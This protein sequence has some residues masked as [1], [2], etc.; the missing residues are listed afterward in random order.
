FSSVRNADL[1]L[2]KIDPGHPFG[3][4]MLHLDSCIHFHEIEVPVLLEQK[5]DRSRIRIMSR[6]GRLYRSLSHLRTKLRSQSDRRR[7]LDHLLVIS[8]DRAVTLS[9]MDHI[10]V[11]V[12]HDL[13][14]DMARVLNKMLN[15]HGIV[16]ECHLSFLLRRLKTVLELL[17]SL[18][19]AHSLSAAA[20][21]RLDDDRIS[22]LCCDLRPFL[23]V[24]DGVLASRNDRNACV[25]H[26]VSC[27]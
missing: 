15:V 2:Y 21:S 26:R 4:R 22:D 17:R 10:A 19:H 13:E 8:L 5:L 20:E 3:N 7:F 16:T 23:A 9:Q 27:L 1:L 6:L 18:S 14:L 12:R 11:L 25:H 24:I